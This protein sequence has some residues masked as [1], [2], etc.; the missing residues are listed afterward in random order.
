[1]DRTT[2]TALIKANGGSI[3]LR[4]G[5]YTAYEMPVSDEIFLNLREQIPFVCV[6]QTGQPGPQLFTIH[7]DKLKS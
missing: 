6:W 1:M 2:V 4:Q 5:P 3:K 7:F